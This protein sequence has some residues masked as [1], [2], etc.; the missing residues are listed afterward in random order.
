MSEIDFLAVSAINMLE[1]SLMRSICLENWSETTVQ[2]Y[3]RLVKI[4]TSLKLMIMGL[5][6]S[7]FLLFFTAL[8]WCYWNPQGAGEVREDVVFAQV[9]SMVFLWQ[10]RICFILGPYPFSHSL[11]SPPPPPPPSPH[12]HPRRFWGQIVRSSLL[13]IEYLRRSYPISQLTR[14][15]DTQSFGPP[16][17]LLLHPCDQS[18]GGTCH[19]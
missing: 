14:Q 5:C 1:N 11:C 7:L 13:A 19:N 15:T 12:P 18:F 16:V 4:R 3:V 10:L 17:R 8:Y 9:W 2:K 6:V